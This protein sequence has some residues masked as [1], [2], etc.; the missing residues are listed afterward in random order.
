MAYDRDDI[1]QQ[2]LYAIDENKLS[3]FGDVAAFIKPARG[4][5]YTW[6]FDKDDDIKRALEQNGIR[7]K[8]K[9]IRKLE[10][11]DN[12]TMLIAAL[13]L[14]ADDDELNRLNT[15]KVTA[16]VNMNHKKVIFESDESGDQG[17]A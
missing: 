3:N 16:D 15:Q 13:K 11:S 17:Q 9:I 7:R 8:I 2:I 12:A 4:T 6:E 14:L 10:E 5:L 1:K